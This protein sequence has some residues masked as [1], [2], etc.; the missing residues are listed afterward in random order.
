MSHTSSPAKGASDQISLIR[1]AQGTGPDAQ[2]AKLQLLEQHESL[3]QCH[4]S[5]VKDCRLRQEDARQAAVVGF[6]EAVARYDPSRGVLLVTYADKFVKGA[7]LKVV[8]KESALMTCDTHSDEG[9]FR[10]SSTSPYQAEPGDI[11]DQALRNIEAIERD[12]AVH[13]FVASLPENDQYLVHQIFWEARSRA[14]LAR[15]RGISRMA[16]TKRL[17]RIFKRGQRALA[18]FNPV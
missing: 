15:E 17:Q 5:L 6:L 3:L 13:D 1:R 14:D 12:K 4:L 16:V 18:L 11:M 7:I 8:C 9:E 10:A 2:A